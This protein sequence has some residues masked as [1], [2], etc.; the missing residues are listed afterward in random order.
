MLH[1]P[2]LLGKLESKW[3]EPECFQDASYLPHLDQMSR[4]VVSAAR[5]CSDVCCAGPTMAGWLELERVRA[6]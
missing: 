4:A 6:I 2:G 5:M 1:V 3:C